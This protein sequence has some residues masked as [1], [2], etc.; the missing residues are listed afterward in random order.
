VGERVIQKIDGNSLS[1]GHD[2]AIQRPEEDLLGG[3]ATARSIHRMIRAAPFNWSTRIGLYGSWG[4]GKT[5]VLNL[6]RLLEEDDGAIVLGFSAW[7]A[8]S[9]CDVLR[10]FYSLLSARLKDEGITFSLKHQTKS[11]VLKAKKLSWLSRITKD[12]ASDYLP[13]PPVVTKVAL[14]ATSE[15]AD[16]ALNWARVERRDIDDL[17]AKLGHRRV[18]IF[19]D[20]LDR[21][22]P[23]ILPKTLLALKEI[24]DWPGFIFVLAFD[25]RVVSKALFE[26][27]AAFG[28]DVQGFLEKV[29]DIPFEVP[30]PTE[31]QK[32]KLGEV[33]FKTCCNLMPLSSLH[34]IGHLL[35]DQPRKIK[36]L[37][38][39][40][41][42]L[43]PAL[44]RHDV[45]EIDWH[46]LTLHLMLV[47]SNKK[48]AEWVVLTAQ[49]RQ[50]DWML[51]VSDKEERNKNENIARE[52]MREL[53]HDPVPPADIERVLAIG[54]SLL[55]TWESTADVEINYLVNL[56]SQEPAFTRREFHLLLREFSVSQDSFDAGAALR[57]S[58]E[59]SG[60]SESDVAQELATLAQSF[61][62]SAL[63]EMA[64]SRTQFEWDTCYRDAAEILNFLEYIWGPFRTEKKF[65]IFT[66]G[67][68]DLLPNL[69][70]ERLGVCG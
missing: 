4:S 15:A 67:P 56:S 5:S 9:E 53:L 2:A 17:R 49:S 59:V 6:L 22:D 7:S 47:E 41:G 3:T 28:E 33:A 27:S 36:L 16:W 26:Y 58:R 14:N 64:E 66:D 13:F 42:A 60:L 69:V 55:R 65:P 61:Y 63:S 38:R 46:A 40:C 30:T 62:Q 52:A 54:L 10:T 8:N 11:V 48:L 18:V 19:I 35:P 21:A 50:R 51:W 70:R 45:G 32:K 31:G 20:D 12:A 23:R 57:R 25:K 43:M 29:V 44:E 34:A 39:M 68:F 24:L 37:A 1:T